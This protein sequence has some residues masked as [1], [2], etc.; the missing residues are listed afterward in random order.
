MARDQRKPPSKLTPIHLALIVLVVAS[1]T[2]IIASYR[3]G[4]S[5]SGDWFSGVLL[6]IGFIMFGLA[7]AFVIG[8]RLV[9]EAENHRW[10]EVDTAVCNR[11]R[12]AAVSAISALAAVPTIHEALVARSGEPVPEN[13]WL[14]AEEDGALRW[15]AD[16]FGPVVR[17]LTTDG[18]PLGKT[19][20]MAIRSGANTAYTVTAATVSLAL[21]R[22]I[23]DVLSALLDLET[24]LSSLI[25]TVAGIRSR[26][27]G[28]VDPEDLAMAI[29]QLSSVACSAQAVLEAVI[30]NDG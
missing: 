5:S 25:S 22:D 20:W 3:Y 8:E 16:V 21:P 6:D 19:D 9:H 24:T 10:Q 18:P 4:E 7:I 27:P 2:L 14:L 13:A 12:R 17:G 26:G 23:P 29:D 30:E 1:I 28:D 15:C 11:A